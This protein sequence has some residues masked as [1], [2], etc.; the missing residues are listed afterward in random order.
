VTPAARLVAPEAGNARQTA[1]GGESTQGGRGFVGTRWELLVAAAYV[2]GAAS[3]AT[4]TC[5]AIA[6]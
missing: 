4:L 2:V 1:H 6:W 3:S 5:A